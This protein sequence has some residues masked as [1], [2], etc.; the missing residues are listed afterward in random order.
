MCFTPVAAWSFP[1]SSI[2]ARHLTSDSFLIAWLQEFLSASCANLRS[3]MLSERCWRETSFVSASQ[4]RRQFSVGVA[5]NEHGRSVIWPSLSVCLSVV[6]WRTDQPDEL[7]H[8]AGRRS[9]VKR[10]IFRTA[11]SVSV[12]TGH[13]AVPVVVDVVGT[14][15]RRPRS[16]QLFTGKFQPS[17]T[18]L[19]RYTVVRGHDNGSPTR[20]SRGQRC[21]DVL[22]S[23]SDVTLVDTIAG[24]IS[25]SQWSGRQSPSPLLDATYSSPSSRNVRESRML[26]CALPLCIA[27]CL[28]PLYPFSFFPLP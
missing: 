25:A 5:G 28:L 16:S 24:T 14:R 20:F 12:S 26:I 1:V 2:D 6:A 10:Y 7:T 13:R 9:T 11:T 8:A 18:W 27:L 4:D 21:S 17:S 3:Q 22:P 15:H 23:S 19:R